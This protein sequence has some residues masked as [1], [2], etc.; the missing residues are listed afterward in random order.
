[1]NSNIHVASGPSIAVIGLGNI[2]SQVVP[3][4]PGIAD[5]RQVILIDPDRYSASNLG[6]QRIAAKHVDQ[7][8]VKIQG[9]ALRA[10]A[11]DIA[12]DTY[13]CR[14]EAMPPGRLRD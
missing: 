2:G 3:L 4:L 5:V 10:L 7:L 1:M 9:R 14:V 12:V 13:P 8:K 6:K 11:P